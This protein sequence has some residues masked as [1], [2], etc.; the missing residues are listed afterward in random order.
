MSCASMQDAWQSEFVRLRVENESLRSL[1]RRLEADEMDRLLLAATS[2]RARP[3]A[4]VRPSA[5]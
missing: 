3:A 2:E 5:H 4:P 1:M